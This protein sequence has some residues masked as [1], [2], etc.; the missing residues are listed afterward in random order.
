MRY[1]HVDVFSAQPFSGNGLIVFPDAGELSTAEMQVLT[2]EMRQF[3][4]IF[5]TRI[6]GRVVRARVFTAEEELDFAGHPV[7][8]A[9]AVLHDLAALHDLTVIQDL[10]VLYDLAGIGGRE[11]GLADATGLDGPVDW[12]FELNEK[13][14]GVS[15]EKKAWGYDAVMNQGRAEFGR[16]LDAVESAEKLG[17]IGT[18]IDHLYP[19]LW[20]TVV[21]TG[22]PYL[23]VPLK[24][25]PYRARIGAPGL[26]KKLHSFGAQFLGLLDIGSR[27]IR[28]GNNEGTVEDIAT[29]SLAGP[30]AAFLVAGGFEKRG[31]VMEFRQGENLGRMSRLYAELGTGA[32]GLPEVTVKGS[33]CRIASGNME[34]SLMNRALGG[35]WR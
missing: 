3:E 12:V 6:R 1:Y 35:G 8:G 2:K 11:A 29:G 13:T 10:A 17:L 14:V 34:G 33:V 21:S 25:N 7:L 19:G 26:E 31:V 18:S 32:D 20:P 24:D 23:I 30:A 15:T 16:V 4:S 27:I 5:L 28:T 9:A 22:L